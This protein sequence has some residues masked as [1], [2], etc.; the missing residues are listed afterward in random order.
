MSIDKEELIKFQKS[1]VCESRN[2]LNDSS[3]LLDGHFVTLS[4]ISLA[5]LI[6]STWKFYQILSLDKKVS[7]E[8]WKSCRSLV[9][10]STR[11]TL[12]LYIIIITNQCS[13]LKK[14]WERLTTKRRRNSV[15]G[16]VKS[17]LNESD[18]RLEVVSDGIDYLAT[19]VFSVLM[20]SRSRMSNV[21]EALAV[22]H[23]LLLMLTPWM[24]KG[25]D[26]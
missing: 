14:L 1:S 11:F 24:M 10:I 26:D 25:I 4:L 13:E 19:V 6:S 21:A 12:A 8:F 22:Q 5:K 15:I 16:H 20:R 23:L 3:T 17:C 2:F 7:V 18:G 9:L